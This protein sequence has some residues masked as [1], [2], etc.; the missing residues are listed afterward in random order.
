MNKK[1]LVLGILVALSAASI[2]A[3]SSVSAITSVGGRPANPMSDNPR[4]QSMFIHTLK[5]GE[6]KTDSIFLSNSSDKEQTIEIYPVDG[7]L[8]NLGSFTCKDQDD[9]RRGVGSWIEFKKNLATIAAR[10]DETIEFE[11]SAPASISTGEL[12]G[13]VVIRT[14]GSEQVTT[15]QAVRVAIIVPGDIH[16]QVTISSFS[17]IKSAET[18]KYDLAVVNKGNVS[19]DVDVNLVTTDVFGN[20]INEAGGEYAVLGNANLKLT[21]SDSVHPFWGGVISSKVLIAYDKRAGVYGIPDDSQILNDT[22]QTITYFAWPSIWA[23][24]IMAGGLLAAVG[25]VVWIRQQKS[26]G[27]YE[28]RQSLGQPDFTWTKYIVK[29]GDTLG[30]LA[31]EY[32]VSVSKL[33]TI[34]K[35][36]DSASLQEGQNIYVPKRR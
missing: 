28:A 4:A 33:S 25:L 9:E 6:V 7:T 18:A 27:S 26:Q 17:R 19:A 24:V 14:V 16:R 32:D 36:S 35:L 23:I 8:T 10:S 22:S 21:F 29:N 15:P 30:T 12:N 11:I 31:S 1:G 20:I 5:P 13:C 34:N 3:G 2:L